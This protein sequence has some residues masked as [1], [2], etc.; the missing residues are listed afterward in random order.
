[1]MNKK[2]IETQ[3]ETE[4]EH[5]FDYARNQKCPPSMKQNLYERLNLNKSPFW[6]TPRFAIAGL[7]LVFVSSLLFKISNDHNLQQD[8]LQQAQADLQVAMHY[9]NQVSFKSL[10]S[11][12]NKGIKPAL[13]VPLA[14]SVATL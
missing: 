5:Y 6:Q 10:S 13:I 2:P 4:L 8:N 3:T 1:M 12:N 7:S 14:R 9:M 11:I